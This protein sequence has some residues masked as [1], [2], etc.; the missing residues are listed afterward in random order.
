MKKAK[1][2]GLEG[3]NRHWLA[4]M[5]ARHS[6]RLGMVFYKAQQH[7]SPDWCLFKARLTLFDVTTVEST[8][9][10]LHASA[11]LACHEWFPG[12]DF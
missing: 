10:F 9:F 6:V 1:R 5:Y 2:A 12:F 4:E 8:L 3:T 11:W 7:Q